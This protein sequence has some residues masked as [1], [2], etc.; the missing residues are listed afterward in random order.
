MTAT[1]AIRPF[2][3]AD[4]DTARAL[5]RASIEELAAGH[6]DA[7][8]R[9]AWMSFADN[10]DAFAARFFNQH[11]MVAERDGE[12]VGFATRDGAMI[13]LLYV[14]PKAARQGIATALVAALEREAE[15]ESIAELSADASL[16]ARAFFAARGYGA[17]R[18]NER[19]RA[20]VKLR[21]TTMTKPLQRRI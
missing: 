1:F 6:Y 15:K 18:D 5:F 11:A 3:A 21:N 4:V 12:L 9:A 19:E 16:A 20:G 10:R 7:E 2:F 8:E 14:S 17:V 13:D